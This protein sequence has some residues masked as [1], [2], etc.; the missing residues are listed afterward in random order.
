M[1]GTRLAGKQQPGR[2]RGLPLPLRYITSG[3]P[4]KA[5]QLTDLLYTRVLP[6]EYVVCAYIH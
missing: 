6:W 3:D 4:T 5:K 1:V 2:G